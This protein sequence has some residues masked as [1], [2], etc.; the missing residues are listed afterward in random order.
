MSVYTANYFSELGQG[1]TRTLDPQKIRYHQEV[2]KRQELL[3]RIKVSNIYQSLESF[4]KNF[5]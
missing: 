3:E 5:S 4:S 1:Q 2:L